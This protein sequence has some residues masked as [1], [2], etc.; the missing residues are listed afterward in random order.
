VVADILSKWEK[1][2]AHGIMPDG[3]SWALVFKLFSF[4]DALDQHLSLTEQEF[5]FEQAV[6]SVMSR[7][8]PADD[9]LLIKLAALRTSCVLMLSL[10]FFSLCFTCI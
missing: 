4:Y 5:L 2:E 8:Y 3:G 9:D 7:R 10:F 1:Y 6:E